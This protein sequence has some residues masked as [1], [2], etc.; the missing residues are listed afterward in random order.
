MLQSN[1]LVSESGQ[2]RLSG[3]GLASFDDDLLQ[4]TATTNFSDPS[5]TM[6]WMAPELIDPEA[7]GINHSR[8]STATDIYALGMVLLEVNFHSY[9]SAH[10][11]NDR[12]RFSREDY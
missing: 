3:F 9:P 12:F 11:S 7:F 5:G 4:L 10:P 8:P 6:R 1:I 2:A